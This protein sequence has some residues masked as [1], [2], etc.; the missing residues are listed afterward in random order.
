MPPT[1]VMFAFIGSR[2]S[3]KCNKLVKT[4]APKFGSKDI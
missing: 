4:E 3:I 1:F 2:R